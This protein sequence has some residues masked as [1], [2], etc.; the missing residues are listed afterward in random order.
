MDFGLNLQMLI[1]LYAITQKDSKG[2]VP[3]GVLYMPAASPMINAEQ[4]ESVESIDKKRAK[5]Y[6]MNGVLLDDID[7]IKGMEADGRG[8]YI[9]VTLK[10]E[11]PKRE[12]RGIRKRP[13]R[14]R[15]TRAANILFQNESFGWF[16]T[17][18]TS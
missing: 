5:A 12:K 18:L 9:P 11:K 3:A 10:E 6:R 17:G 1:Y 15:W 16:S 8:I 2:A 13:L 14:S 7:V 4:D